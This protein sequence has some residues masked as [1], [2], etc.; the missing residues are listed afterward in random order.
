MLLRRILPTILLLLTPACFGQ[1]WTGVLAPSRATDWSKA[2]LPT[3]TLLDGESTPNPWTPPARTTQCGA[4]LTPRGGGLDDTANIQA[5]IAACTP[6]QFVNMSGSFTVTTAA[7]LYGTH[8]GNVFNVTLRGTGPMT[9]SITMNSG[10]LP[11]Q[12]GA[13]ADGGG[14]N[15]TNLATNPKGQTSFIIA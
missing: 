6:G 9:T 8:I 7:Q 1:S 4:T 14:G 11:I 2:G 13:F 3:P 15:I 12:F 5:A 10:G